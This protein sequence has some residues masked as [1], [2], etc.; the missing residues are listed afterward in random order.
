MH[1]VTRLLARARQERERIFSILE[2]Q[3]Q[4]VVRLLL[5]L[6]LLLYSERIKECNINEKVWYL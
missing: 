1:Y 4:Q 2:K 3:L 5:L 6:L